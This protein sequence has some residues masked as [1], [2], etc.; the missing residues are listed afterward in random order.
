M[1]KRQPQGQPLGGDKARADAEGLA[2]LA[3]GR[4]VSFE[5][6]HRIWLYP[7]GGGP[8]RPAPSPTAAFPDNQGLEALAADPARGA[9]AYVAGAEASGETWL[10]RLTSGCAAGPK[11]AKPADM[12]LV[13]AV[14]V[15]PDRMAW[16]LRGYD[17]LRGNRVELRVTDD[18]LRRVDELRIERPATVDNFEGLAAVPR[19]D[20]RVR[21]YMLS[22]DNF[23]ASQRT[24]LLAFDWK[25]P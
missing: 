19:R 23:S 20:G 12:G 22:D 21:F 15:G 14:R 18:A 11:I 16:L 10:C 2:S 13:A 1:Y 8:P 5:H 3:A 6:D 24:L 9:D 17:P 7:V 4:L 25:A